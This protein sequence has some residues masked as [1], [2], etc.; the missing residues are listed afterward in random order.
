MTTSNGADRSFGEI[1]LP[2]L[3]FGA[4]PF[5]GAYHAI[6]EE[7]CHAAVERSLD[8]G[9]NYFD[10]SP[11][12]GDS[13]VVLGEGLKKVQKKYPRST[14][15][16]STK[17]GRYGYFKK[18]FDYSGQRVVDS[19]KESMRRLNTDYLDI[20]FC[21]DVEFV[22]IDQIIQE[23]LPQLFQLKKEGKIRWVGISGYP[24]DTLLNIARIQ[25]ERNQPLDVVLS[26]CHNTLQNTLYRDYQPEF[27]KAGVGHLIDA[28]PLSMGLFRDGVTP[29]WHPGSQEMKEAVNKAKEICHTHGVCISDI[30][31]KYSFEYQGLTSTVI[32]CCKP[33]EIQR[34]YEQFT[35]VQRRINHN[36]LKPEAESKALE[37]ILELLKPHRNYSWPSPP[38]DA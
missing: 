26:Y 35:E 36:I 9:I 28:S 16:I 30:A 21:H 25:S 13:E 31:S 33:E 15:Y 23:T 37:S 12:Y 1:N 14:Y 19:V 3:G 10:T 7:E 6:S 32:G 27:I 34:A 17:I 29:E 5:G 38:S 4:G 24:L 2:K 20:V 8:L 18:D 11:Y 22:N